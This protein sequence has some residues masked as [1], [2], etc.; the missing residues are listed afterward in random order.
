MVGVCEG[1][2]H[3]QMVVDEMMGLERECESMVL[4]KKMAG[5]VDGLEY[6]QS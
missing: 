3:C 6:T 1:E 4:W 2:A 5:R